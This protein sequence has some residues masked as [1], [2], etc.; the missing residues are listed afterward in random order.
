M[1]GNLDAY[2]DFLTQG[3][4]EGVQIM[5][6]PE[7]GIAS[8]TFGVEELPYYTEIIPDPLVNPCE[9]WGPKEQEERPIT[10]RLS[11]MAKKHHL[12]MV[13]NMG[14]KQ[15]GQ[16]GEV[17]YYNTQLAYD[18]NGMLLAKYHKMHLYFEPFST[19]K[20][21]TP[22]FFKTSFGVTFGMGICFDILFHEPLID[23]VDGGI[24]DFVYSTWWVN[25][26]PVLYAP[27]M[28]LGWST[29]TQSNLLASGSGMN[30][31]SSGSGIYSAGNI[32]QS[33]YNNDY[34]P[35]SKLLVADVPMLK[36]R[37]R[38]RR[39]G[40]VNIINNVTKWAPITTTPGYQ[41]A[42]TLSIQDLKCTFSY[43]IS[44][45]NTSTQSYVLAAISGYYPE[46]GWIFP[47]IA[48][49]VFPCLNPS[50][51]FAAPYE[52]TSGTL[53]FDKYTL[54][55]SYTPTLNITVYPLQIS[56]NSQIS[57]SWTF[58]Q[59]SPNRYTIQLLPQHS[60]QLLLNTGLLGVNE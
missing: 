57:N 43:G 36:R 48:C 39:T 10:F 40:D 47:M 30:W 38:D 33:F 2:Q 15:I 53:L 34:K 9:E 14:D 44:P 58:Q 17:N 54:L 49:L 13:V 55:S 3:A 18:E 35:I 20:N 8:P 52:P 22:Q 41:G 37:T 21:E 4:D 31:A 45:N 11:C 27:E 50:D 23:L 26:P 42:V 29:A 59:P 12:V 32:L 19:P 24:T 1:L 28:Q 46:R 25:M 60:P 6:F 5:V 51:C 7:Y 16:D 56:S